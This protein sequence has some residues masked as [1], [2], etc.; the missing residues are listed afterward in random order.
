MEIIGGGSYLVDF[1]MERYYRE[2]KLYE[3]AGGSNQ[4][5]RNMILKYLREPAKQTRSR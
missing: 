5:Q 4:I 2:A 3:I 1:G